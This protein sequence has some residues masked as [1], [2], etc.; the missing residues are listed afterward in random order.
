MRNTVNLAMDSRGTP[1]CSN[2]C[3]PMSSRITPIG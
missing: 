2:C 1:S 3:S